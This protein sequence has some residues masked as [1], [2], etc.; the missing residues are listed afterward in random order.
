M[1]RVK[2]QI[3]SESERS[4]LLGD[5]WSFDW[6]KKRYPTQFLLFNLLEASK[7]SGR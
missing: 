3:L 1:P 2:P 4:K 7:S 6:L 5:L